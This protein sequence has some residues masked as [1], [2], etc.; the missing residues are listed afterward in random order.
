MTISV[1]AAMVIAAGIT[2]YFKSSEY[3][4]FIPMVSAVRRPMIAVGGRASPKGQ[5]TLIP[6]RAMI[7]LSPIVLKSKTRGTPRTG[8]A[9]HMR[10]A[11]EAGRTRQ[12]VIKTAIKWKG[13]YGNGYKSPDSGESHYLDQ[14]SDTG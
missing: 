3:G 12:R 14:D 5:M 6:A 7:G 9:P 13:N 1:P 4:S 8:A 11:S 2:Q 10:T